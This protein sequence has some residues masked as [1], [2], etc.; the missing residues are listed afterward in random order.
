MPVYSSHLL[1]YPDLKLGVRIRE[2]RQQQNLTL[3]ELAGRLRTSSARLS[4]IENERLRLSLEDVVQLA[5][6]LDV[7]VE[8][9][10]PS[11]IVLPYQITRDA[12]TRGR[13]PQPTL[14]TSP[15]GAGIASPHQY[16]PLA[17]LFVGRHLEPVLGRIMPTTDQENC[18][19]YHHE[20]EFAFVLRGTV[21]FRI[22]TPDGD[23]RE[24]LERGDCVYFRSDLPH[25]FRSL[26]RE[27]ADSIHVFCSTGRNRARLRTAAT[28]RPPCSI[29]R[30][31]RSSR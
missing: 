26:E 23:C 20:E 14:F 8:A 10:I 17:N 13:A 25:C 1:E 9:L 21:E 12:A 5:T 28:A 2:A 7:P 4:Q 11:D 3:R 31:A 27:P 15:D 18:F 22:K 19:C 29:V 24:T 30:S 6:A 16:W